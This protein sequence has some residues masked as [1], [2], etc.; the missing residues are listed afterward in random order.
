MKLP[1]LQKKNKWTASR[2]NNWGNSWR[3]HERVHRT[4]AEPSEV[5]SIRFLE[6][7]QAESTQKRC[8]GSLHYVPALTLPDQRRIETNPQGGEE[9]WAEKKRTPR[10]QSRRSH[11]TLRWQRGDWGDCG[12]ALLVAANPEWR[13]SRCVWRVSWLLSWHGNY[14]GSQKREYI[15]RHV[16][17]VLYKQ[18]MRL[19]I[20]I[21]S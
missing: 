7:P 16:V 15:S 5:R 12:G 11:D 17:S 10:E 21:V 19:V 8:I 18:S 1:N 9:G 4:W 3:G 2:G 13:E 14:E 6:L 20:V